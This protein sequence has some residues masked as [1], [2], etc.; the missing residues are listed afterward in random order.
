MLRSIGRGL[1][2][3]TCFW[4]AVT[5]FLFEA[6]VF[7]ANASPT[8]ET[9]NEKESYS[10]GYQIGLS[11]KT[12]DIEVDF[13]KLIQGVQ[14]AVK[15]KEP[16]LSAEEMRKLII[17]LK[18]NAREIQMRMFQEQIV[19]NAEESKAFLEQNKQKEGVKTTGSG[20]QYRVLKE[21]S[22]MTPAPEDYVKVNY[23]GTFIDG[24]EFDS[25]YETGEP[26]R[27][28]V[29]GVIKG[30]TEALG[31]MKVDSK[32]QLFVPPEL[33]YGRHGHGQRI[34]PNKVLVFEVELLGIEKGDQTGQQSSSAP[35]SP[36]IT[37]RKMT[38]TGGL[39]DEREVTKENRKRN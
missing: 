28:R 34:P 39:D 35:A 33:A 11:M 14:D 3:F 5:V 37:V 4:V 9:Q 30:W 20:L 31:M 6:N 17:D 24:R 38:L 16:L 13:E 2:I 23:R 1:C 12:D 27:V 21:G 22:G 15:G 26:I 18:R 8:L 25:S 19:E 32:W 29:N 7:G 10:I 36:A